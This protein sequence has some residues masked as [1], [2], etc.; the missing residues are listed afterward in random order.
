[1]LKP[2]RKLDPANCS[3]RVTFQTQQEFEDRT[4]VLQHMQKHLKAEKVE[5]DGRDSNVYLTTM[6]TAD[7]LWML[8]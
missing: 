1:M 4:K 2:I 8:W 7:G 3:Y 6:Q 5:M